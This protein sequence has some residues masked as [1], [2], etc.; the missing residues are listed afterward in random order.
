MWLAPLEPLGSLNLPVLPSALRGRAFPT[1][2]ASPPACAVS[3]PGAASR[4][5]WCCSPSPCSPP[6]GPA[7]ARNTV[8]SVIP[9]PGGL[10]DS[11]TGNG[12]AVQWES[13]GESYHA[14]E[15]RNR[16]DRGVD[17]PYTVTGLTPGRACTVQVR[18]MIVGSANLLGGVYRRSFAGG[19]DTARHSRMADLDGDATL[20]P[21]T[22]PGASPYAQPAGEAPSLSG[23]ERTPTA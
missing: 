9:V 4:R 5:P 22:R 13:G 11:W 14:S 17:S 2:S 23:R 8:T 7:Q 3:G 16:S 20:S 12:L 6:A 15:R 1:P 21:R 10:V 18:T 19:P